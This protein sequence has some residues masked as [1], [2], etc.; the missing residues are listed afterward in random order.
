MPVQI[1]TSKL[2]TTRRHP[3]GFREGVEVMRK[4]LHVS[5]HSSLRLVRPYSHLQGA[6]GS[7]VGLWFR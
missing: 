2:Y 1:S 3:L 5:I 6:V 4:R 7:A